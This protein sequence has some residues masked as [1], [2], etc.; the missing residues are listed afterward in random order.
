MYVCMY[1][2]PWLLRVSLLWRVWSRHSAHPRLWPRAAAVILTTCHHPPTPPTTRL[3]AGPGAVRQ[4]AEDEG[5]CPPHWPDI[6]RQLRPLRL[7][8]EILLWLSCCKVLFEPVPA[9]KLDTA[10]EIVQETQERGTLGLL[11]GDLV[12]LKAIGSEW[13][14]CTIDAIARVCGWAVSQ[15]P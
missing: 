7:R 10:Q 4:I 12:S 5:H 3:V 11:R 14:M 8:A 13:R 9:S 15:R 6:L 1:I 2:L